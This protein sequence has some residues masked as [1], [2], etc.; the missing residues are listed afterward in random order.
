MSIV[1]ISNGEA[2]ASVT[3]KLN[4]LITETNQ[5]IDLEALFTTSDDYLYT[6][7]ATLAGYDVNSTL[8]WGNYIDELKAAYQLGMTTFLLPGTKNSSLGFSTQ[9]QNEPGEVTDVNLFRESEA[10]GYD[11]NGDLVNALANVP[12]WGYRYDGQYNEWVTQ[13]YWNRP[14]VT[15]VWTE[16]EPIS[17]VYGGVE[18]ISIDYPNIPFKTAARLVADGVVGANFMGSASVITGDIY[19][20]TAFIRKDDLTEPVLTVA[21]IPSSDVSPEI[22][23]ALYTA[24]TKSLLEPVGNGIWFCMMT[25]TAGTNISITGFRKRESMSQVP[26]NV[27]G[28]SLFEGDKFNQI[29]NYRN[30]LNSW[31]VPTTNGATA[32]RLV[33]DTL[34]GDILTDGFV[35]NSGGSLVGTLSFQ[36]MDYF[37]GLSTGQSVIGLSETNNRDNAVILSI[38][39]DIVRLRFAIGGTTTYDTTFSEYDA[40]YSKYVITFD[41]TG[42]TWYRNGVQ[43]LTNGTPIPDT[44]VKFFVN[45]QSTTGSYVQL[46]NIFLSR[47]KISEQNAIDLSRWLTFDQMAAD[48]GC[49]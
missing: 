33:D 36:V 44:F 10:Y 32:T 2:Q 9:T 20:M 43:L 37:G 29:G 4:S 5:L 17:G 25:T 45:N 49:K 39:G 19:T 24:A 31:V 27:F 3:T 8:D 16:T 42:H 14:T 15:N 21:N 35:S 13:G 7:A 38:A 22:A 28:V 18:I 47:N 23:N 30:Y 34:F 46:K 12:V 48:L 1:N 6:T 11:G 26:I 41:G 40:K